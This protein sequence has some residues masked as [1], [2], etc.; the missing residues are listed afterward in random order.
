MPRS[1]W[2]TGGRAERDAG[3]RR[4][5]PAGVPGRGLRRARAGEACAAGAGAVP[6]P[7][8]AVLRPGGW[9]RGG[10]GVP[11]SDVGGGGG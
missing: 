5:V 2:R 7:A 3:R 9:R 11:G 10:R 6:R 8:A 4:R 1:R